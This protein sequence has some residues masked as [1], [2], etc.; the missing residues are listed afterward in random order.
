MINKLHS[1]MFFFITKF[2][3]LLPFFTLFMINKS[4]RK[5]SSAPQAGSH[6]NPALS[7]HNLLFLF[8]LKA[9]TIA[10]ARAYEH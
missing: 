1:H 9:Y 6:R 8:H 5:G 4:I 10:L 3:I 2:L 7:W